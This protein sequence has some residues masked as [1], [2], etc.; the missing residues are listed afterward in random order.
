[1]S[2]M[3]VYIE[4]YGCTFN[5][6]DSQ[7]MAGLLLENNINIC[8]NPQESDIILINTCYVKY[9]TEQKV[10]NRLNQFQT[11]F[12]KKKL[13]IA[14]CMVEIDQEK[15][16]KS[17][18][19]ASWI[20]PHQVKSIYEVV[21]STFKG[22]V[23]RL[24]GNSN[25]IKL[26]LPKIRFNPLIHIVQICEGCVGDCSYCCTKF[27]RGN[28]KSYPI[29]L[30]KEEVKTAIADGC[31]EI[32]LTAQDTAAYGKDNGENLS[33][34]INEITEIKG[35][36]KLRI[37]MMHP[38]NLKANLNNILDAFENEKVYKFLHIPLQSGNNKVLFDMNRGHDIQEFLFIIEKF[39]ERF[40][41]I[42]I[43]TDVIV[44]YPTEDD[45]AFADTY[46]VIKEINPDFIHI[47][48]YRHRPNT[49]ASLMTEIDPNI[50]NNR[51]KTLYDLKSDIIYQ[52]N[53]KMLG[54]VKKVLITGKGK[55]QN[56]MSRTD[57]YKPVIVKDNRIGSFINV[58]II[59]A[60]HT[61]L[62]GNLID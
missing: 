32:Q 4:T 29:K 54:K 48:K 25:D 30:I 24:I 20:G 42:S 46:N 50:V 51:S 52:N 5:Q 9:P 55:K 8:S 18:P 49:N 13:I 57:S 17:A 53:I 33:D 61:Y 15:L 23:V 62:I 16:K 56:Y 21:K 10:L 39:R 1:M 47:S 60:S 58:K 44:G 6:A 19:K 28:L 12:P 35:K 7:I 27:A 45:D 31:I 11:N 41:K 40:P 26:C 59:D 37:G 3:N 34:V 2:Q 36:F 22:D 38:R 14:G 43:A